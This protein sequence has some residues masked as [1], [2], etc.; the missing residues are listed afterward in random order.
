MT[1]TEYLTYLETIELYYPNAQSIERTFN[2]LLDL[3]FKEYGISPKELVF[4]NS[5]GNEY[6]NTIQYPEIVKEMLGPVNLGGLDGYPFSGVSGMKAFSRHVPQDGTAFILYAS[7][8]GITQEGTIGEIKH[9]GQS[10][11]SDCS[12]SVK[13]ALSKLI[14][15]KILEGNITDSDYQMNTIEQI[16]LQNKNRILD[17]KNQIFE[18]TEVIYEAIDRQI[19][20]LISKTDFPCKNLFRI[21]GVH[22]NS[23]SG[24]FY[25]Y[26]RIEHISLEDG[27]RTNLIEKYSE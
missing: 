3:I 15:G 14:N 1:N 20:F 11:N 21:G 19:D 26:K 9:Q 22:I 7:H 6:V 4:A 27:Q 10:S 24:S 8:I 17:A 23:D 5:L 16:L 25:S 12:A 13:A 2:K 18:A